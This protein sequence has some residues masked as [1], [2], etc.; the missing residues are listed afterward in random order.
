MQQ[1]FH[2]RP[3]SMDKNHAYLLRRA[4]TLDDFESTCMC[5][6]RDQR[7]QHIMLIVT[8]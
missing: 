3:A 6:K 5:Q 2:G 8:V 7:R 4:N 1:T